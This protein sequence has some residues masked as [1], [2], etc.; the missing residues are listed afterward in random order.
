[1]SNK[2]IIR[3][4]VEG[5]DG[6]CAEQLLALFARRVDGVEAAFV[7]ADTLN[8]FAAS[9]VTAE[10]IFG[11]V[12]AAGFIPSEVIEVREAVEPDPVTET[13]EPAAIVEQAPLAEAQV[14]AVLRDLEP[15]AAPAAAP[16]TVGSA[17][18]QATLVQHVNVAVSDGYYPDRIE[19]QAG[20]PVEIEFGEGHGCLARVLFEQFGIDR[21]LTSGGATVLLPALEPGEYPFSCGMKMVFGAVVAR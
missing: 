5:I 6:R 4:R 10:D 16:T 19:V 12:V 9:N 1:M 11:A 17:V 14:A 18:G 8:V 3:V 20:I 2:R 15:I 13:A 7:D 21:D